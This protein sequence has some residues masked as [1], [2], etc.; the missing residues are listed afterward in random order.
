VILP[1]LGMTILVIVPLEDII[2]LPR[3]LLGDDNVVWLVVDTRD[4][5]EVT[6]ND[7]NEDVN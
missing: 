5:V 2:E 7:M 3:L 1:P 4:F 6:P